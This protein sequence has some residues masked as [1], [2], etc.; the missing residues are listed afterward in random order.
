MNKRKFSAFLIVLT[1]CYSLLM[2]LAT[3]G[4]YINSEKTM[5]FY[6][7]CAIVS[8]LI[9]VTSLIEYKKKQR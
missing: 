5:F 6:L 3:I 7:A 2:G 1:F 4:N 9:G 8:F